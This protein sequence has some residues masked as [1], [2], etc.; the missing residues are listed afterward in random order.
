MKIATV[1]GDI[2]PDELGIALPHEHLLVDLS[3]RR[4]ETSDPYLSSIAKRPVDCTV[5]SDLRRNPM[6]SED[7]LRLTD[8]DLAI[9]E[10]GYF[11]EAGGI[12]LVDQTTKWIGGDPIALRRISQATGINIVVGCGYYSPMLPENIDDLST[13]QLMDSMVREIEQGFEGTSI[14]AGLIGEIGTSWP[15][16][17]NEEKVLRA[18]SR[19]QL[20]T[21][22]ALSIHPSPWDKCALDLLDIVESEGADLGRVVICHLDHVMDLEYH[23]A[24]AAR[25]AYV[26]YDRFGVEWYSSLAFSL[27]AFPRDTERVAG[28]VDLIESGYVSQVLL[29]HD[30]CQKIELKRY[31]GHGYGH[32]LR[33][34]APL[35]RQMGVADRDIRTILES[36]PRRMLSF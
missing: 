22:V 15:L 9:E 11:K 30:V 8:I 4:R 6:I 20:G 28:V 17:P 10:L 16:T 5:V 32:I 34:V 12:S 31:G 7:S 27:R 25:G 13:D 3:C 29:S 18:A 23:K 35:M 19:A 26:E 33:Y 1:C 2:S 24:V 14:R 36:N 21:G